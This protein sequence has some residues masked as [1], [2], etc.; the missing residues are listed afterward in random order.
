MSA[1]VTPVSCG[2][3]PRLQ[4]SGMHSKKNLSYGRRRRQSRCAPARQ[5][6]EAV[7]ISRGLIAFYPMAIHRAQPYVVLLDPA[8]GILKRLDLQSTR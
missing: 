8:S 6:C 3:Q 7:R 1:V 2:V 4:Q 5:G